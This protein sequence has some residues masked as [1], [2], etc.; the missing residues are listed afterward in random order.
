M[1]TPPGTAR[2][3]R[4]LSADARRLPY[5]AAPPVAPSPLP[6]GN[7]S[8][9]FSASALQEQV[10]ADLMLNPAGRGDIASWL[11]AR[12]FDTGPNRTLYQLINLRLAGG[13]RVDPL[14]I[15]WDASALAGGDTTGH[16]EP[17]AA[18]ALRLGTLNPA[19]GTAAV[20]AQLLYAEQVCSDTL[21]P[22]WQKQPAPA[23]APA[24]PVS[25]APASGPAPAGQAPAT[26]PQPS[27]AR[28]TA[29]HAAQPSAAP[30]VLIPG[31]PPL[32]SGLPA[33]RPPLP[34][35]AG[36]APQP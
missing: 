9:P 23:R 18:A 14:I 36:P 21:G 1:A 2:L 13:R 10:L 4:A 3:A 27:P 25:P 15:A 32:A 6:P 34:D 26:G 28:K 12:V 11:P 19:P 5:H 35:P 33:R 7:Q 24:V 29:S 31:P 17:L 16:G 8:A 20:L 30:G 22:N